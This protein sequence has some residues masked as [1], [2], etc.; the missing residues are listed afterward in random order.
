MS[1]MIKHIFL[2]SWLAVWIRTF[3]HR[4]DVPNYERT[5]SKHNGEEYFPIL[6]VIL[7]GT[8]AGVLLWHQTRLWLFIVV[9]R[10]SQEYVPLALYLFNLRMIQASYQCLWSDICWGSRGFQ[11]CMT[12]LTPALIVHSAVLSGFCCSVSTLQLECT[13]L[14]TMQE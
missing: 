3:V 4:T 9:K 5:A 8:L 2:N 14:E 7:R 12:R 1:Q 10:L 13:N 6:T 11:V